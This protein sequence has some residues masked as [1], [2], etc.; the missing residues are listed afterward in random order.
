MPEN[1]SPFISPP[2][3]IVRTY[4]WRGKGGRN[5]WGDFLTPLILERYGHAEAVWSE[6]GSA[7]LVCI[8]SILGHII[9]PWFTGT[10]LGAGKLFEEA[11][12]PHQA[13]ILALRGPLSAKH[14]HGSFALGDPGLLA[15]E[16]VR[17]ETKKY[18]LCIVPHFS[19][20]TLA[21]NP[22][23]TKWNHVIIDPYSDPLTVIRTMAESAKVVSSSLHGLILADALN[24]P[25]RFEPSGDW[26]KE[27]S[28]FKVKD[29][30]AAVGLPFEVGK[31]Q[32]A[33]ANKVIDLKTDLKQVFKEYRHLVDCSEPA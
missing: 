21:I 11:I 23:F 19:D 18:D 1:L 15:D 9:G 25:R 7:D 28:F 20:K 17:I 32:E 14:V 22:E 4:W 24:L 10:I 8:G 5:N 2:M 12:V 31:L 30:N 26:V 29:H 27:G 16:L 13:R 6:R 33:D 3:P